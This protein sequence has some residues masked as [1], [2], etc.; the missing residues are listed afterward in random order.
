M[1]CPICMLYTLSIIFS[2]RCGIFRAVSIFTQVPLI[3]LFYI[4]KDNREDWD[5]DN[6]EPVNLEKSIM[7]IS[8]ST[9]LNHQINKK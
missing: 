7:E 1:K 8:T 6:P 4:Q 2:R 3:P 5:L 9:C